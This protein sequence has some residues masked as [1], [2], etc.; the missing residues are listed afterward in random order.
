MAED[1]NHAKD[2]QLPGG[3]RLKVRGSFL[4]TAGLESEFHD[5]IGDPV[6]FIA[7]LKSAKP[8]VADL[9]TFMQRIPDTAP[10]WTGLFMEWDNVAAVPITTYDY[11]WTRQI[12]DKTR[13]MARRL[14]KKGGEVRIV[15]FDD[16]FVA[17]ICG[18]YNETPIRQG[19]K[20]W[21]YGKPLEA[22]RDENATFADRTVFIGAYLQD[23]LI[24]FIKLVCE[25]AFASMMQIISMIKHRDKSPTNA[26][27]A[28][29]V[30]VCAERRIP[31]L[32]YAKY[33]YGRK[34]ADTLSE[35]KNHNA[36]EQVDL[37]RYYVPLTLR[38][39]IA[40]KLRLHHGIQER[41]PQWLLVSLLDLRAKLNARRAGRS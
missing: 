1:N 20:F 3:L 11:W 28:K 14:G 19:K 4:H 41:L 16:A 31:Y 7:A 39:K 22:V 35:F 24:G 36:F 27:V 32:V 30:E 40:L 18:I 38:G 21:H 34:G 25:P 26:L 23:E 6:P 15:P 9:F 5:D 10:R 33:V 2:V 12:N 13:N 37:P 29:A 8:P 17:G